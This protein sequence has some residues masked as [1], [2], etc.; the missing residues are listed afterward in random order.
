M[1][2]DDDKDEEACKAAWSI[3]KLLRRLLGK[4]RLDVFL[5]LTEEEWEGIVIGAMTRHEG[6][7][8]SLRMHQEGL[9]PF[10]FACWLCGE[11]LDRFSRD[12][13]GRRKGGI[14][15][16]ITLIVLRALFLRE[17]KEKA[18]IPEKAIELAHDMVME[19]YF[20]TA[21]HGVGMNGLYLAFHYAVIGAA[22][23]APP[24]KC[25]EVIGAAQEKSVLRCIND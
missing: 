12:D 17:T 13:V 5:R 16:R 7:L 11:M 3:Q 6:H 4:R 25:Y 15:L 14:V 20:G 2:V 21:R 23:E 19:E 18:D 8:K 9:D 22:Q 10:K 24:P 1:S